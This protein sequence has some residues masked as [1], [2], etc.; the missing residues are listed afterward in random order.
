MLARTLK[1]FMNK[2]SN[3]PKIAATTTEATMTIR[4][5]LVKSFLV[6]QVT[7]SNSCQTWLKYSFVFPT[8][9]VAF[10]TLKSPKGSI[11]FYLKNKHLSTS[12]KC[13]R[14]KAFWGG[15]GTIK[16]RRFASYCLG[17]HPNKMGGIHI[18]PLNC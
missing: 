2:R 6:G 15:W 4:T 17:F 9:L 8:K 1:M 14:N 12:P 5:D 3:P 18:L 10:I 16:K 13:L 7:F 11:Y